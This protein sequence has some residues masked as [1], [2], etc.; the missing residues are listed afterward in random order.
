MGGILSER[1]CVLIIKKLLS[2]AKTP[3]DR[4]FFLYILNRKQPHIEANEYFTGL[5]DNLTK[6]QIVEKYGWTLDL[7]K[8]VRRSR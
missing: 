6:Q 4:K 7:Q 8:P 2:E 1:T 3:E 5:S